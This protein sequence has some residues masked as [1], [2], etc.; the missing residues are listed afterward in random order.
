M[1]EIN[2]PRTIRNVVIFSVL[3][4]IVAWI[5]PL[6]D[7][8]ASSQGPGFILWGISPLLISLLLRTA[9]R[10]WADTGVKPAIKKNLRWYG[11]SALFYPIIML[12]ALSAG[13][14][15][16]ITSISEFSLGRYLQIA[17]TALPPF[18][19]FAVFEEV[20]WRGYLAPKL[21]ALGLNRY[22]AAALLALVWTAWHVPYLQALPWVSFSENLLGFLPR[23]FLLLFATS[24]LYGEI[25]NAT[26]TFWAAVLIHGVS[27][28]FGHPLEAD[29]VNVSAGMEPFSSVSTG[30]FVIAFTFLFT[31]VIIRWQ[32]SKRAVVSRNIG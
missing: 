32:I 20:G 31:A 25:R 3:V 23:F 18:L 14:L 7:G 2:R 10:D 9:T 24:L 17:L 30:F 1:G 4:L 8:N 15:T 19:V 29:F 26:G 12:L 21:Y 11:I 5:A 16:S 13:M 27:N 28:A 6:L 22:A